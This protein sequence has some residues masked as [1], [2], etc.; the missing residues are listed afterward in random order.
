MPNIIYLIGYA[1]TGKYTIAK[2]LEKSGYV[3][4][5]NQLINNPINALLNYDGFEPIPDYAWDT[6]AK[7]RNNIFDFIIQEPNNNYVLTNVLYD[8]EEDRMLYEQVSQM[9]LKRKSQFFPVKLRVTHEENLKRITQVSRRERWKS[10]DPKDADPSNPLI[11]IAHH[12]LLELDIT[13]IKPE[14]AA[15][16]ILKHIQ[17]KLSCRP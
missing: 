8:S 15:K 6:I 2:E 11:N 4:C 1:G 5:D 17:F 7:I 16:I 10:I 12:N 9:A 13:N 14:Q 3:I